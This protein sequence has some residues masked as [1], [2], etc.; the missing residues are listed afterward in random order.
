MGHSS[1]NQF[2]V[3]L[4]PDTLFQRSYRKSLEQPLYEESRILILDTSTLYQDQTYSFGAILLHDG[5]Y[6]LH[7]SN[8]GAGD[9]VAR[10]FFHLVRRRSHPNQCFRRIHQSL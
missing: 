7:S 4:M 8:R 5:H 9:C 10:D 2:L 3:L 6:C 1:A